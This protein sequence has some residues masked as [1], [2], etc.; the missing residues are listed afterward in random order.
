MASRLSPSARVSKFIKYY[1][2]NLPLIKGRFSKAE[3]IDLLSQMMLVKIR[4]YENKIDKDLSE[5]DIKMRENLIKQ[6]QKDYFRA[7]A[8]ILSGKNNCELDGEIKIM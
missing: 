3:A 6:I 7:R 2:M 4:Y 1:I 5:E 8:A